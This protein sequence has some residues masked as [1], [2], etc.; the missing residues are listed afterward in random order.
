MHIF[1]PNS[2]QYH[3]LLVRKNEVEKWPLLTSVQC[4]LKFTFISSTMSI[5]F[6]SF[7]DL[8]LPISIK[9]YVTILQIVYICM[10]GISVNFFLANL[11][12]AL[13]YVSNNSFEQHKSN[14]V[15][16]CQT[17]HVSIIV[18]GHKF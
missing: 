17:F 10:S 2:F 15:F 16:S 18:F 8:E 4:I 7:K 9:I 3:Q 12:V 11:V 6:V 13:L 5:V 1:V 14:Y